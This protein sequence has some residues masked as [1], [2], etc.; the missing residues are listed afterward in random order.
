MVLVLTVEKAGP[1]HVL[2][3]S[4]RLD[5]ALLE[6]PRALLLLIKLETGGDGQRKLDVQRFPLLVQLFE[7]R[8]D[9]VTI[10]KAEEAALVAVL[11][12]ERVGVQHDEVG[13]LVFVARRAVL[14]DVAFGPSNLERQG[15]RTL[16]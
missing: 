13:V 6:A 12:M 16:W 14:T 8:Q 11:V 5:G 3:P 9:I 1:P 15:E 4:L 7:C 10:V 2:E